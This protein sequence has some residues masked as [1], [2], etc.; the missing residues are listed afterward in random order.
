MVYGNHILVIGSDP[1]LKQQDALENGLASRVAAAFGGL[2]VVTPV[3]DELPSNIDEAERIEDDI[4]ARLGPIGAYKL[5]ATI[6]QV[7][8]TLGLPRQFF[9]PT[10]LSRIFPD[11]ADIPAPVARQRGVESEYAFRLARDL[12]E[13][14]IALDAAG[15]AAAI[16][17][18][19]AAIEVPGSRFSGLGAHGGFALVADAG[20]VGSLVIGEGQPL[21]DPARLNE[22]PVVLEIEGQEPVRG[23]GAI[24]D[25]GPF[26]PLLPFVRSALARGYAL[27]AGMVIVS[28]S[29]TGYVEVPVGRRAT[30]HFPALGT[31]ASLRFSGAAR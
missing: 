17:T 3:A 31:S 18:V 23:G 7:R 8:A 24:I 26:G 25:G 4:I 13:A 27:K 19:H 6:A 12:T 1:V 20:A 9:G 28:G 29:C 14:D 21:G 11:G 5:G 2:D 10:P 22:A 30:A 16:A 15:L